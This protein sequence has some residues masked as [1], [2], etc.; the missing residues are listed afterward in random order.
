MGRPGRA[1]LVSHAVL[2]RCALQDLLQGCGGTRI[3]LLWHRKGRLA[4]LG[5][6]LH[7]SKMGGKCVLEGI[8]QPCLE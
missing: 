1:H 7:S 3:S 4:F 5:L 8:W 6:H 2:P